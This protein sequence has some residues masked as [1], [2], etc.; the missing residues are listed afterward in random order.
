MCDLD[1]EKLDELGP[2]AA[3]GVGLALRT[4]GDR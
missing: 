2:L 3:V 1:P 4:V